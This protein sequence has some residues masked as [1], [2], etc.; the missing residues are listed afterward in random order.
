MGTGWLLGQEKPLPLTEE[1]RLMVATVERAKEA[2]VLIRAPGDV[3][4]G[5][6]LSTEGLVATN[7]H[8]VRSAGPGGRVR[9]YFHRDPASYEGEVWGAAPA[10]DLALVRVEAPPSRL[11]PLTPV[12]LAE[13]QV[14]QRALAVGAPVGLDFT[15]SEGIVSAVRLPYFRRGKVE[16]L[17]GTFGRYVTEVIQ[18]TAPVN[19]GN[20]GGPL[21]DLRGRLLGLNTA[22][23]RMEVL[24][25][26]GLGGGLRLGGDM[27]QREWLDLAVDEVARRLRVYEGLNFAVPAETLTFYLPH[28]R[29]GVVLDEE[30]LEALRPRVGAELLP[31]GLY[32][33]RVRREERLP[34]D[35]LLVR[36]VRPGGPAD[37]AGLRGGKRSVQVSVERLDPELRRL[38]DPQGK[39]KEV[40]LPVEGDVLLE[41]EG[42]PLFDEGQLRAVIWRKP[43][44][45]GV[46]LKV[47]RVDRTGGGYREVVV[48]PMIL[49]GP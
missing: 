26:G 18:T 43:P 34:E 30:R 4:S 29:A 39:A 12:P 6:V 1:E 24:P 37:R 25:G 28:L 27:T 20:S 19:P 40:E 5:V 23:V 41:A 16:S 49:P 36:A 11:R 22:T 7:W 33:E 35:G 45:E 2:T 3:G 42:Q 13:I 44:G 32:P 9:V 31:L 21:V 8:V 10:L 17:F 38:L 46:R 15:V 48:R 47:L 14:G